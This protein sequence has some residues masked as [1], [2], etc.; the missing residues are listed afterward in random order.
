MHR[1]ESISAAAF[2]GIRDEL[3]VDLGGRNLLMYGENGFGKSSIVEALEYALTGDVASLSRR[4]QRISLKRHGPHVLCSADAMTTSAVLSDNGPRVTVSAGHAVAEA[5]SLDLVPFLEGAAD[6]TF[7]L[8]RRQLLAFIEATDDKSRYEMLRP[9]VA[10]DRYEAFEVAAKEASATASAA[11]TLDQQS[12]ERTESGLR[13]RFGLPEAAELTE[14]GLLTATVARMEATGAA[15][16]ADG[17]NVA[18]LLPIAEGLSGEPAAL[19]VQLGLRTVC[20]AWGEVVAAAG[21]D[22]TL[23]DLVEATSKLEAA[24]TEQLVFFER[25]LT[26]GREWIETDDLRDCPLCE[27]PI[28]RD[29]VL[30]RIETRLFEQSALVKARSEYA[31]A[32]RACRT[33]LDVLGEALARC[34]RKWR[35]ADLFDG[36]WPG[37]DVQSSIAALSTLIRE[38]PI[39]TA[40]IMWQNVE[41]LGR[42]NLVD[43]TMRMHAALASRGC[44]SAGGEQTRNDLVTVVDML[45]WLRDHSADLEAQRVACNAKSEQALTLSVLHE[46]AETARKS[47]IQS[48]FREIQEDIGEIYGAFHPDEPLG[49]VRIDVKD[50]ASGSAVIRADFAGRSSED[51]RAYYSEAHQDTLGLAIYLALRKRSLKAHPDFAIF[52][53]DDVLSSIDA[54]HGRR[55][56]EFLTETVTTW[57]QLVITTHE[58]AWYERLVECQRRY[59]KQASFANRRIVSFTLEEGPHVV[60]MAGDYTRLCEDTSHKPHEEFA[61]VAGRLLD[62]VCREL[63]FGWRLSI[64]ARREERYTIGDIWPAVEKSCKKYPALVAVAVRVGATAY[65]RN[66]A[67]HSEHAI[68]SLS[69]LEAMELAEAVRQFYE[70]LWCPK[71]GSMVEIVD[72]PR[73]M[74]TCRRGCLMYPR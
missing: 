47:V 36:H 61:P 2:R 10:L 60:D 65:I 72:R 49:G 7:I 53:V 68:K 4:G 55:V 20:E 70:A 1:V 74:L 62:D 9:F 19:A 26:E 44:V 25:V 38:G 43:A 56:A 58:L 32:V 71:C 66:L 14:T 40:A 27:Q 64:P 8:R 45:R 21:Q 22:R 23:D 31:A 12:L 69:R 17:R 37:E 3:K 41:E 51:P 59:G 54:A 11:A 57:G 50:S 16:P 67:A 28:D 35:D 24:Q 29:V 6:G 52:V 18:H 30:A 33:A 15:V 63:R 46:I 73:D 48:V 42:V 5:E 39:P 13:A 34:R